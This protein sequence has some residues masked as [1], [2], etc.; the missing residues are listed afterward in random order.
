MKKRNPKKTETYYAT[1]TLATDKK[2]ERLYERTRIK[3][4]TDEEISMKNIAYLSGLNRVRVT[5]EKLANPLF[6]KSYER[7]L[8]FRYLYEYKQKVK[9]VEEMVKNNIDF[10]LASDEIKEDL[11]LYNYYFMCKVKQESEKIKSYRKVK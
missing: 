1:F 8:R 11:S 5:E 9:V 7:G 4:V 2:L 10:D 6:K 3:A